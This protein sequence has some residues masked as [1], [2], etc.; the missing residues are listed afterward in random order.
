MVNIV[1]L[2]NQERLIK[3]FNGSGIKN[4]GKVLVA[5]GIH[6]ALSAISPLR[7]NLLCIQERLGEMSGELLAY[8]MAEELK[9]KKVKIVLLGD[10]EAIPVSGRKPFHAVLD[11]TLS[12]NEL[13]VAILEI[14]STPAARTKK[15]KVSVRNKLPPQAEERKTVESGPP[16]PT[17]TID[18]VVEI[19]GASPFREVDTSQ[20]EPSLSL[21]LPKTSFQEKLENALND[22]SA[23]PR[24]EM[25]LLPPEPF[26]GPLRVTWGKPSFLERIRD[27]L[28]QPKLRMILG[29]VTACFLALA[30]FLLFSHLKL[31]E[32]A[33]V[34]GTPSSKSGAEGKDA[35]RPFQNLPGAI[36]SFLPRQ[37]AD[38]NYG[39]ANPGWERYQGPLTEFR[40]FREKGLI[41]AI[42][43][44]DRGGQGVSPGL[45][46]SV[47][48][49]IAGSRQYVIEATEQK[50]SYVVEKGTVINGDR[51][52][53]Y[54]KEPERSVKAFVLDL[55]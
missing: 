12:D 24:R 52:I 13:A 11:S 34:P 5:S 35:T 8:R 6:E 50:G 38:S 28:Q 42:Q 14:L 39:K 49:E 17:D 44:I 9:G 23:T 30:L 1:L 31:G 7:Q 48:N 16:I 41:R 4:A 3:L 40:I 51:I 36:P 25:P 45:L 26:S 53:V 54:R 32:I 47:L 37:A 10:P 43:I 15:K 22:A 46:S 27:R 20:R 18:D 19:K 33:V 55:K 21:E 29:A 2:T